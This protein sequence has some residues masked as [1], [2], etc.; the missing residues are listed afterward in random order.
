MIG[1]DDFRLAVNHEAQRS[2]ERHHGQWLKRRVERETTDHQRPLAA[3]S[4]TGTG[5][6][7]P[8][9]DGILPRQKYDNK[10]RDAVLDRILDDGMNVEATRHSLER[11]FLLNLST[12][13]VYDCLYNAAAELD[14]AAHRATKLRARADTLAAVGAALAAD[15]ADF[16]ALS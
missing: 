3:G 6:S 8:F 5:V 10:V 1:F 16:R 13:F 7:Q 9:L 14:M 11:D 2:S 12:G 15:G 4:A